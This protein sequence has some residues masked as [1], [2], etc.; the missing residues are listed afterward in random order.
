MYSGAIAAMIGTHDRGVA[1]VTRPAPDR[2]APSAARCAAPV[3]PMRSGDDQDAAEVALVRVGRARRHELAHALARQ[4]LEVRSLELVEHRI[5]DADVGDHQIAAV[6]IGGRKDQRDLRRAERH[7]HRRFDRLA[8][9]LV[10]VGRHAGRQ[11]DRHDRHAEPVD[12][13][14]DGLEQPAQLAV[15]PG[16]ENRVDDRDRTRR[17]R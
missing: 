13:G 6:R 9:D 17:S 11:I 15:K 12:V 2:S 16:A 14:D 4:E 5:R 7:R 1:M 3:R 8:F 10:R